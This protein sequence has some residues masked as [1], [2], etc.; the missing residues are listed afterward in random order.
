MLPTIGD[1]SVRRSR[2]DLS[3]H[4][5]HELA[6][7][8]LRLEQDN[9]DAA[10]SDVRILLWQHATW[11]KHHCLLRTQQLFTRHFLHAVGY[12][13]EIEI[14]IDLELVQPLRQKQQTVEALR[15]R[16]LKA[17]VPLWPRIQI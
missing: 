3:D 13:R 15:L 17:L 4:L 10:V 11:T 8:A 9:V 6:L 7:R 14:L 1:E 5:L 16:S 12:D 2:H